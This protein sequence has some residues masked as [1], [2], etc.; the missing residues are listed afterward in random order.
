MTLDPE[1]LRPTEVCN[2]HD[3]EIARWSQT[4]T[5]NLYTDKEKAVAIF[6][7]AR[8]KIVYRFDYPATL[9]SQTLIKKYG[10][11]LNK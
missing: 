1:Y 5:R 10:N 6:N 4:L 8:E 2:L 7:F 11:C 3:P 9:A